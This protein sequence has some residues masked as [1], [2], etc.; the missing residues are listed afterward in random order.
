M[1]DIGCRDSSFSASLF[2]KEVLTLQLGFKDDLFDLAQV[3]LER[4]FPAIV[5][6][7]GRRRLP[8]PSGVFDAIHCG[9]CTVLWHSNG[10]C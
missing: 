2:D 3:S 8:F 6:P 10:L 4:G 1:L 5:S 7:F 9:S